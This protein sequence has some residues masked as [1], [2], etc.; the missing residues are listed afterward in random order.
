MPAVLV[1]GGSGYLGQFLIRA[2]LERGWRTH[3]TFRSAGALPGCDDAVGHEVDA[4]DASAMDACVAAV[5]ADPAFSGPEDDSRLDLIVNCAAI[6]SPGACE[7]D[8]A[9]ARATNVPAALLRALATL[10]AARLEA[11]S[12]GGRDPPLLIHLST[13]QVYSGSDTMSAESTHAARPVN[14]Y[15][16]SK[17]EA[18]ASLAAE[19]PGRHVALRSSIITGPRPPFRDV[20]RPLFTDFIVK[21][22]KGTEPVSFFEDEYRCP[23]A[24][25]DLARVCLAFGDGAP[26]ARATRASDD[27]TKGEIEGGDRSIRSDRSEAAEVNAFNAGGP[28]RVSRVDMARV[29]ARV[30]GVSDANVRA[31]PSASVNRGVASPADISMDSAALEKA[32]GVRAMSFEE[33][34]RAALE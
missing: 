1:V 22:L 34:M 21:S 15:G 2:F 17:A 13:D 11:A 14:A 18:E 32:T 25:T 20:A 31:V 8:E 5:F 4:S 10:R 30:M 23:I 26:F 27:A 6:S 16:R 12:A 3:Y 29:A 19:Y 7:K 28:D 33:Q 9:E 24:A